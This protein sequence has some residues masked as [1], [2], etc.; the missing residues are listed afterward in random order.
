MNLHPCVKEKADEA[1]R[2]R[3]AL[4]RIPELSLEE[5]KTS[6]FVQEHLG[7][8]RPDAMQVIAGTGVKA[9]FDAGAEKTIAIRADI[10]ALPLEERT[11]L[12]FASQNPGCMHACGHD[13]HMAAALGFAQIVAAKRKDL[14]TNFVFLFQPAEET[15]GGAERMIA[16]GALDCPHVDEIYGIHLWP[17]LPEGKVALKAGPL[18]AN[19]CDVNV[20]MQG[21][22]A[23]GAAPHLGTDALLAAA[24]FVVAA[25]G[26]LTRNVS[27]LEPAVLNIGRITAGDARNIV[28]GQAL[29]EGT[30]R[31]FSDEL[32]EEIRG[33]V[34]EIM[35]G[36]D[37]AFGTKSEYY[38]T[39]GYP[40][41]VNSVKLYE[42]AA[43]LFA[44]P[45]WIPAQPV[46]MSEDFAYFTRAREGLF[47]FIGAGEGS[48]HSNTFDFNE[49]CLSSALEF[50]VRV[51]GIE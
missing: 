25:Q 30:V 12:P 51:C 38:E 39:M 1:V 35:A 14:K 43:G 37:R 42:K 19:M 23:H 47:A 9:V 34:R 17:G 27:P 10:D 24:H 29:V 50:Y 21:K 31:S 48:L 2:L 26:I 40:A 49:E 3:R 28:C 32:S 11:G 13:G 45:E 22:T 6:Q 36:I 46:M 20:R 8:L 44:E 15:T 18:M 33:R 7:A 4:H 5:Y 16:E 41:L